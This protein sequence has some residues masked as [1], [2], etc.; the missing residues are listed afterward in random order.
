M[1]VKVITAA[2]MYYQRE[3]PHRNTVFAFENHYL[4]GT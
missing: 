2:R 1:I 3:R 4:D